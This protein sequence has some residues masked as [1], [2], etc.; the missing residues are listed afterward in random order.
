MGSPRGP[1]PHTWRCAAHDPVRHAQ[2]RAWVQQRNQAQWRGEL[3][4]LEFETW[5]AIWGD[6]WPLRGRGTDQLCMT[7]RDWQQPWS[8]HNAEIVTRRQHNQRQRLTAQAKRELG[9]LPPKRT[10]AGQRRPRKKPTEN[11]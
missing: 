6:Q 10:T 1:R 2:Y 11:P 8:E 9:L 3:W 7:R 5:I 4:D